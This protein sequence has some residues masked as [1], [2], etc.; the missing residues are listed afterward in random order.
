MATEYGS[1]GG[2]SSPVVLG[3][4][5]PFLHG[6]NFDLATL[7]TLKDPQTRAAIPDLE[8]AL[9][10]WLETGDRSLILARTFMMPRAHISPVFVMNA[11]GFTQQERLADGQKRPILI[12]KQEPSFSAGDN[13]QMLAL[14]RDEICSALGISDLPQVLKTV[15]LKYKRGDSSYIVLVSGVGDFR[16]DRDLKRAIGSQLD[17]SNSVSRESVVNPRDFDTTLVLGLQPGLVKPI[18]EP[19]LAANIN[20]IAYLTGIAEPNSYVALSISHIDTMI[21]RLNDFEF[22]FG[23]HAQDN[24]QGFTLTKTDRFD[25]YKNSRY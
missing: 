3:S 7:T 12:V 22:L 20:G 13:A 24:Y 5:F 10:L 19:H 17:L 25:F 11:Y 4:D 15:T 21:M 23:D 18:L 16:V 14:Q 8:T 9:A 1:P 6:E 2:N